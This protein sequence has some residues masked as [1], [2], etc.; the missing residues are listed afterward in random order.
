MAL[1]SE[2]GN[3]E[4]PTKEPREVIDRLPGEAVEALTELALKAIHAPRKASGDIPGLRSSGPIAV[5][6]ITPRTF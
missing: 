3:P 5:E 2:G 6:V 4:L 1:H